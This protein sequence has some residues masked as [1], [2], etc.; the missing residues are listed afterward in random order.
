[1]TAGEKERG[2]EQGKNAEEDMSQIQK[3]QTVTF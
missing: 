2:K 3:Q 1:M